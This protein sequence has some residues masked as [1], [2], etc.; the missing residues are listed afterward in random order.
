[1]PPAA[2]VSKTTM[3]AS[4]MTDTPFSATIARIEAMRFGAKL[5]VALN[6]GSSWVTIKME[7]HAV[8][9]DLWALH[10]IAPEAEIIALELEEE[11]VHGRTHFTKI[12]WKW[13][14]ENDGKDD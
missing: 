8:L 5:I 4:E 9:A 10:E 14:P 1:M 7:S 12:G 13:R 2:R 6:R 3:E 11:D